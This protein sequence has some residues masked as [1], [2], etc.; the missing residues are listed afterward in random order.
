MFVSQLSSIPNIEEF[1][2]KFQDLEIVNPECRKKVGA[3][4]SS[5]KDAQKVFAQGSYEGLG[6]VIVFPTNKNKSGLGFTSQ[7]LKGKESEYGSYS[8]TLHETFQ[9]AGYINPNQQDIAAI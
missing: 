3:S 8:K 2:A 4:I 6:Q 9:S 5:W 1:E 7:K